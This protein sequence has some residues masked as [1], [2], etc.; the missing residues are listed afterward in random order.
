MITKLSK[1]LSRILRH[2]PELIGL[3]LDPNGW[4]DVEELILLANEKGTP[5]DRAIMEQIVATS[6]KQ[7]FAFNADKSK[8]RA[9]QGHSIAVDLNLTPHPPEILFHG[10]ATRF[11]AAIQQQGLL[12]GKR[13]HVHLS[14][15]E[16]IARQVGQ[17][18]GQP[19]VLTIRAGVMATAGFVFF[20]SDNGVWLTAHVPSA[21]IDQPSI[22]I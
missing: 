18:H 14:R 4:A 15:S 7:R 10:T 3:V 1:F 19:T 12:P 13:Q 21:Y 20:C 8:I 9:N 6:D 11:L 2:Q 22:Q 5:L 16:S 17:R